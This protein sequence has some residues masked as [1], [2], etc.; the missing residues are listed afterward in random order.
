MDK[1]GQKPS[2]TELPVAPTSHDIVQLVRRWSH[3]RRIG[4]TGTLDPMASGL[5]VL[6]LGVATRLAEYYQ[7]HAKQYY[8][9]VELGFATDT[10]DAMGAVVERLPVPDLDLGQIEA[11]LQQF[12]GDILQRPPA[13]SALKQ[14]GES[15]HRRARR[16]ETVEPAARPVTIQR[17]DLVGF[18]PPARLHLRL[19]CSAGTYVRSVAH[20]LGH[21]LGTCAHLASLRRE[22]AGPF[23]LADAHAL[24]HIRTAA[25]AGRLAELILPV[26]AEL[27]LPRLQLSS[28]VARR[29]GHGQVVPLPA[30]DATQP[31]DWTPDSLAQGVDEDGRFMGIVRCLGSVPYADMAPEPEAAASE[32]LWK[33]EKWLAAM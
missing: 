16:G 23:M 5:L 25:D 9:E 11:G 17:L 10:Y 22:A 12:R 14:E 33:A 21:V 27:G 4:H 32:I 20:D 2:G 18:E 1:P 26:G 29:L 15:L 8:A 6:C 7:G 31:I 24:S 28:E 30:P 13:Y 19:H 3:Q